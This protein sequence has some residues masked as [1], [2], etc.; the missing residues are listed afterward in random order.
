MSI[1]E[2]EYYLFQSDNPLQ[3]YDM[4]NLRH[5]NR[6]RSMVELLQASPEEV[7]EVGS[8]YFTAGVAFFANR[9]LNPHFEEVGTDAWLTVNQK[10]VDVIFS[11]APT[12]AAISFGVP[13]EMTVGLSD[14]EPLVLIAGHTEDHS[15]DVGLVF[16]PPEI[17]IDAKNNP[18]DALARMIYI[19]SQLYDMNHERHRIDVDQ[20]EPRAYAIEAQ[21]L[22]DTLKAYPGILLNPSSGQVLAEHPF[23]LQGLSP[24]SRYWENPES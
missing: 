24:Q 16:I 20:I 17:I 8:D 9:S 23:G 18:I 14:Q 7:F 2:A 19:C 6:V 22:L 12:T 5:F 4:M 21:F 11:P 15:R 1:P 3:A 10:R 13:F